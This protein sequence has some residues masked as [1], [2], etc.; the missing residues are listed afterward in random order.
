M[1]EKSLKAQYQKWLWSLVVADLIVI[2]FLVFP[3]VPSADDLTKGALWRLLTT[4]VIPV[5]VLLVVNVLPHKVKCMLV[6]WKPFGWLPGCEAFTKYGP[7]DSRVDMTRLASNVGPLPKS[8]KDQN[9]RWYQLYKAKANEVEVSEAHKMFL[10][11][12]DMATITVFLI[13]LVPLALYHAYAP[14][15]SQWIAACGLVIQYLVTALSAR[16]RG[17][18]FVTNVVAIHS[19]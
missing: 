5:V 11:Y 8:P 15:S 4:V 18:R 12:R 19:A 16:H 10:M 17:I 3:G 2:L 13:P 7:D 14:P 1:S 6:Y 9:A